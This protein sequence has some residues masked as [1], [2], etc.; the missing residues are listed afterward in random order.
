[1]SV[2]RYPTY[3]GFSA[4][5][6]DRIKEDDSSCGH[7]SEWVEWTSVPWTQSKPD[8]LGTEFAEWLQTDE[9]RDWWRAGRAGNKLTWSTEEREGGKPS[10]EDYN[11][12]RG[13]F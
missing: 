8:S 5:I 12:G 10:E 11:V 3:P 2:R 9:E 13:W 4:P 6:L 1:M 7:A